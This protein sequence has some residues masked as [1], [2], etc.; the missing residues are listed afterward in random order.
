MLFKS[1]N[2]SL[3]ENI[4]EFAVLTILCVIN[5]SLKILNLMM[6]HK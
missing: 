3:L 6:S 4:S 2:H 5:L 1:E